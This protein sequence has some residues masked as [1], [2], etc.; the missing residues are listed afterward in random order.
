MARRRIA[1]ATH[2][3]DDVA[4]RAHR[5]LKSL[6]SSDHDVLCIAE[7]SQDAAIQGHATD[8]LAEQKITFR[9][10]EKSAARIRAH[11]AYR[12]LKTYKTILSEWRADVVLVCGADVAAYAVPAARQA[13]VARCVSICD[14]LPAFLRPAA[15]DSASRVARW[16]TQFALRSSDH[17]VV[18]NEA[19][20]RTL[21]DAGLTKPTQPVTVVPGWGVALEEVKAQPLADTRDE[22]VFIMVARQQAV[23]GCLNF[24]DAVKRVAA[25]LPT[26][27]FVLQ[28]VPGQKDFDLSSY[29]PL[30]ADFEFRPVEQCY[31]DA[32]VNGHVF[33]YP[34][35]S[36]G[37]AHEVQLALAL[38]R[39]VIATDTPGCRECV[40][41]TVNGILVE[42]GN[43]KAL[44]EAMLRMAAL[45]QLWPAMAR[46]SRAKAERHFGQR[47]VH[48]TLFRILEA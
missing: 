25:E 20:L 21:Q 22:I 40:D 36:E 8:F 14:E 38:G 39:P 4:S 5:F 42:R 13:G 35:H 37:M 28:A 31:A 1:F 30:R 11:E 44:C 32:I 16:A 9:P 17:V 43:V 2:S 47:D 3:L 15:A 48:D 7:P 23:R 41:E 24:L 33:V 46:A 19:N 18:W 45:K 26:A 12:V 6:R 27:R 10:I 34:S 29:G